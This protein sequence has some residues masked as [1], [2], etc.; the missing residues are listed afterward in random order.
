[1]ASKILATTQEHLDI[2]DIKDNIVVLKNGGAV[3]V[4]ETTAINFDLLSL[5]EQDAAI[6]A[7]SSLLNSLSF[8]IQ[9]TMRSKRM[10]ISDYLEKVK[11]VEAKQSSS[12][13]KEQIVA[14]R[15]FIK[16]ELVTK[17]EVLDKKFYVSVPYKTFLPSSTPF[18]WIESLIEGKKKGQG[19]INVDKILQEAKADLAPKIDFMIKEFSRIGI[20][21]LQLNTAELIKLFYEIYNSETSQT[22]KIR[23]DINEYTSALV[24]PKI[25]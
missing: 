24:E 19:K 23:G 7:F 18:G 3:I 5:R 4:L 15:T 6:A 2:A 17:G 20:K 8:P 25:A 21:A 1:M 9:I 12:K 14:Y 11:E 22:Q 16:D 13:I 10:D